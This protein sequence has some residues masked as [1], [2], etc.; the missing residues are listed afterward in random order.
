PADVGCRDDANAVVVQGNGKL[1][2]VGGGGV[3]EDFA[4]ARYNADGSLD[5]SFSGDGKQTTDFLNRDGA[6]AV[7]LQPNGKIVAVG[8]VGVTDGDFGV[9][10]FN[11][12][13]SLD[14]SFSGDGKETT[15]FSRRELTRDTGEAPA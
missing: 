1:V 6:N 3:D 4:L 12:N 7:A 13:G 11:P 14:T 8:R 5:N 10:R 15:R 2:A 9:A